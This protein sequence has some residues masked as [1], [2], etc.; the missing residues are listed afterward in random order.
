MTEEVK[1][2]K[3]QLKKLAKKAEKDAKK[4]KGKGANAAPG[5]ADANKGKPA[6]ATAAAAEPTTAPAPTKETTYYLANVS[7]EDCPAALKASTAAA[8]F[9]I[10]LCRASSTTPLSS[11]FTGPA[12][13]AN[14]N[15]SNIAFGGNGIAKALSLLSSKGDA[16]SPLVDEWLEVERT[17][18]RKSSSAKAKTAALAKVEEA[19]S[20]SS[21]FFIV[22][23]S[24]TVADIAIVVSLSQSPG[25]YSAV[26]QKYLD[27]HLS[28]KAFVSGKENLAGLVPPPPFDVQ[29]NPSM[30]RAVNS[31]FYDALAKFLPHLAH[32]LGSDNDGIVIE[33]SKQLKFGDYQCKEAMPLFSK[34]KATQSLPAG[35][36]SPQQLAQ[37]IVDNI[38][39]DNPVCDNI[40]I[41][42]PGFILVKVKSSYLEHH[43]NTLMNSAEGNSDPK[44]PLPLDIKEKGQTVVVDFSSP[45]IAKE[46]H[47]GHLRSTIIGETV[48]R[49]LEL[50][51]ADVKRVNHV[52]DW[53]TQ[54]GMLITYLKEAYPDFASGDNSDVAISDLTKIYK[55][56]KVCYVEPCYIMLPIR[57]WT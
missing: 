49:I 37:A 43:I 28:S 39:E 1:L 40:N 17:S 34:L 23:K 56:A 3:T 6:A 22:G 25:T 52:G 8:A 41:N 18:L 11:L 2:S 38:P 32:T 42:G 14:S 29:N 4:G 33:K 48:C 46:M 21:G 12:L 9:G 50:V 57:F 51:G 26:V 31:V 30:L 27:S 44:M 13:F 36:N 15:T 24:F 20:S 55:K 47:V 7:S 19:L 45:N 10:T 16:N 35:V 5:A 54:F 53:G